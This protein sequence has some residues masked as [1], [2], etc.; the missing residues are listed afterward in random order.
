M[1]PKKHGFRCLMKF[2]I[3]FRIGFNK[4]SWSLTKLLLE[5]FDKV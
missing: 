2:L 3:D 5:A 4:L 1:G